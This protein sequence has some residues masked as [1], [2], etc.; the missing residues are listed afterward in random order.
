MEGRKKVTKERSNAELRKKGGVVRLDKNS[1]KNKRSENNEYR[2]G[3][4]EGGSG[5]G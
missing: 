2:G 5:G 4:A 1:V 3:G